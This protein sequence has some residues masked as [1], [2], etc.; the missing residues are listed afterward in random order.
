MYH[1]NQL[2][3]LFASIEALKQYDLSAFPDE[4]GSLARHLIAEADRLQAAEQHLMV[5]A[6]DQDGEMQLFAFIAPEGAHLDP[7]QVRNHLCEL[8]GI[9]SDE[10]VDPEDESYS[11]YAI[12]A[13][14]VGTFDGRTLVGGL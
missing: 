11:V 9:A 1:N 14:E 6:C 3:S 8:K 5:A 7:E 4:L 2:A 10:T 13:R 12:A